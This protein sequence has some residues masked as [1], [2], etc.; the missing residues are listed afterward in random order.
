[1]RVYNK[2]QNQ[3]GNKPKYQNKNQPKFKPKTPTKDPYFLYKVLTKCL[4][5]PTEERLNKLTENKVEAEKLKG[6]ALLQIE[7][8]PHLFYKINKYL[9]G[10]DI[11][12]QF[13]PRQWIEFI[14]QLL[15]MQ[16]ITTSN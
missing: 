11:S 6:R 13:T 5:D 14:S 10:F 9:N 8:Y 4:I 16:N 15:K 1:M 3:S 2:T 12:T 7:A